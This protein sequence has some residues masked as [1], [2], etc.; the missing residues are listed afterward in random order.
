MQSD[1]DPLP[2]QVLNMFMI[3]QIRRWAMQ[4]EFCAK[5]LVSRSLPRKDVRF[6]G[7]FICCEESTAR[8]ECNVN[9]SEPCNR[10]CVYGH[11][12]CP[13]LPVTVSKQLLLCLNKA[14]TNHHH[15]LLQ[16]LG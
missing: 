14:F 11:W 9:N 4:H 5:G 15:P 3:R 7:R 2:G 12:V 1:D 16:V 8:C 10:D 6:P 13:F